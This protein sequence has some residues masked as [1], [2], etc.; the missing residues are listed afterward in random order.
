MVDKYHS[1]GQVYLLS[2]CLFRD[3][4]S[5]CNPVCPGTHPVDQVD[6]KLKDPSTSASQVLELKACATTTQDAKL[7]QLL[8]DRIRSLLQDTQLGWRCG[9]D[10]L[11]EMGEEE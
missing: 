8:A 1:R 7:R 3:R 2:A 6:L 9:G 11:L 4:V 5:L 10:I